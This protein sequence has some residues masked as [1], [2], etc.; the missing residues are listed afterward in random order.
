MTGTF[1]RLSSERQ[2]RLLSIC[3]DE[4]ARN[5]YEVS[6]TNTIVRV[7]GISKG[8]FFKYFTSKESVYLHLV[9]SILTELGELQTQ[10]FNSTDI[11]ARSEEL[12]SRHMGYARRQPS[13]YRM[14]LRAATETDPAIRDAVEQI[15]TNV[16]ARFSAALYDGV[17]WTI[18]TLAKADVIEFLRCLDLGLR[19]A[20]IESVTDLSDTA[21]FEAYVRERHRLART[22]LRDGLYSNQN[23]EDIDVD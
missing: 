16:S 23:E 21:G 5:G 19:R 4:F 22:V 15:R 13:R 10:P 11:V 7:A 3:A 9:E 14:A 20:A 8:L 1:R 6:S 12:F 17:D 18:Y 2:E